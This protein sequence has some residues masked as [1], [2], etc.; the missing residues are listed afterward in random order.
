[1]PWSLMGTSSRNVII[2]TWFR[3]RSIFQKPSV[4][5]EL[6]TPKIYCK[7]AL[8]ISLH[9]LIPNASAFE[10]TVPPHFYGTMAKTELGCQVLTEKG[11]FAEFAHFIRQHGLEKDDF[12]L[13]LKLKSVLW[14]VVTP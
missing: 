2:I 10:G 11:H 4:P 1:M 5:V 12:D 9:L 3:L 7:A 8:Y 14:A 13:I 6:K